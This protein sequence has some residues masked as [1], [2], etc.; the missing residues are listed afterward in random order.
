MGYNTFKAFISLAGFEGAGLGFPGGAGVWQK[1]GVY[2][3]F[4]TNPHIFGLR[5]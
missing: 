3:V 4:R 2:S 1:I 5:A